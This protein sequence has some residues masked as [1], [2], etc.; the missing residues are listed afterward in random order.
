M[1]NLMMRGKGKKKRRFYANDCLNP[2]TLCTDMS[3]PVDVGEAQTRRH[4]LLHAERHYFS[5]SV[6]NADYA[7]GAEEYY[8]RKVILPQVTCPGFNVPLP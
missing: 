5:L 7:Q 3:P 6:L 4:V 2:F 8:I 1:I